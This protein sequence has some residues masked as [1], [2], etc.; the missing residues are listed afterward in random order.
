MLEKTARSPTRRTLATPST[1]RGFKEIF[2]SVHDS[3]RRG[4]SVAL[5][6]TW[7]TLA[8]EIIPRDDSQSNRRTRT[9]Y[10]R[11]RLHHTKYSRLHQRSRGKSE[12]CGSQP[13]AGRK[14][15]S[16]LPQEKRRNLLYSRRRWDNGIG[17][18][19]ANRFAG[20]RHPHSAGRAAPDYCGR[21]ERPA[22]PVLLCATVFSRRYVFRLENL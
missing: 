15:G 3:L 16:P 12:P 10:Y 21:R 13:E 18:A 11:R 20:G 5:G 1:F 8:P 19:N 17:R 9:F 6:A 22:F 14:H 4:T 7:L 2:R